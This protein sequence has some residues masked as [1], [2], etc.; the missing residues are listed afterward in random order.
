MCWSGATN[1]HIM[2]PS[3]AGP[4]SYNHV[5]ISE[6]YTLQTAPVTNG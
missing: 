6:P 4:N 5:M 3:K 2:I 1:G